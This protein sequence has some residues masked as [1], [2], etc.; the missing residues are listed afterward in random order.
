[1]TYSSDDV[2]KILQLAMEDKQEESFSEKQLS[3]M[4]LELGISN[5]LL[6]S[7]EQKWLTQSEVNKE[8][9]AQRDIRLRG[10]RS[11]LISFLVVN[12]FLVVLN[13]VTTPRDFWAIYPLSGWGFGLVMHKWKSSHLEE[14]PQD[15]SKSA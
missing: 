2:Q 8:Q 15:I 6:K 12:T 9:K 1:M 14:N 10:F 4:A 3:E 7:A 5:E 11:H 13:L